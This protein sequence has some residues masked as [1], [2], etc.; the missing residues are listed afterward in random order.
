MKSL[1]PVGLMSRDLTGA[2]GSPHDR[3]GDRR[4]Q[5]ARFASMLYAGGGLIVASTVWTLPAS[6]DRVAP[7]VLS[8]IAIVIAAVLPLAP[9][10]L[11]P[12]WSLLVVAV[13]GHGLITSAFALAPG[14]EEHYIGLV[15]LCY[16]HVGLT[17]PRGTS[18][19]LV[20]MTIA[21][22]LTTGSWSVTTTITLIMAVVV[23]ESLA[24]YTTRDAAV[25]EDIERVLDATRRIGA[26]QCVEDAASILA[27]QATHL[28]RASIVHV[29]T[30]DTDD[31]NIYLSRTSDGRGPMPINIHTEPSGV[32][33]TIRS[34]EALFVPDALRSPVV[35]KRLVEA[36]GIASLFYLPLLGATGVPAGVIIIGWMS[37]LDRLPAF[38]T[39]LLDI[40]ATDAGRV[41]ERLVASHHLTTQ[42]L[43]DPL[44]GV[45]NRRQWERNLSMLAPSDAVVVLDLDH[46]KQHNDRHGHE[47]GDRA[48]I[49]FATAMRAAGRA[50]DHVHRLGGD[51]FA[52]LLHAAQGPG[53]HA[54]L[55]R[56][57][58]L[59]STFA[60]DLTFSAGWAI[61]G[62]ASSEVAATINR[63]D[64]A[65]Y[66]AKEYGRD[67]VVGDDGAEPVGLSPAA[68]RRGPEDEEQQARATGQ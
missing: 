3:R 48:L 57:A 18:L 44:T 56:L 50:N 68:R 42:T 6:I 59:W 60:H 24:H 2:V 15:V 28:L 27:E 22:V 67:H 9:W 8:A 41:V 64:D 16:L 55:D 51:E 11:W 52:V 49:D 47:G 39:S 37:A 26:S 40:L 65:L 7:L 29:Y 62:T 5:G 36:H 10:R 23:A 12:T 25:T 19:V 38:P 1:A 61:H 30:V 66:R 54:F 35:S 63:A 13:V 53:V 32:G 31:P 21:S 17:Q 58:G 34:R 14:V 45:G 33:V 4:E 20:P 43:T 46:F